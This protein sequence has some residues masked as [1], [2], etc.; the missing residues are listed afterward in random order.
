M[1]YLAAVSTLWGDPAP[2]V[3]TSSRDVIITPESD[4]SHTHQQTVCVSVSVSG[5]VCVCVCVGQC[6]CLLI[7]E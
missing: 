1:T 3:K 6:G 4:H 7:F 5:W 2:G